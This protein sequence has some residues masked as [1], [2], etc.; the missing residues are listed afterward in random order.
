M[1]KITAIH[2]LWLI[3]FAVS[4]LLVGY[5]AIL[6]W[7]AQDG[8]LAMA[9]SFGDAFGVMNCLVSACAL[10]AIAVAIVYQKQELDETRL[11]ITKS[12]DA[13]AESVSILREEQ[14]ERLHSKQRAGTL[15]VEFLSCIT[16]RSNTD[17]TKI[18]YHIT[19]KNIG[20]TVFC[21]C[22]GMYIEGKELGYSGCGHGPMVVRNGDTF[23]TLVTGPADIDSAA[24]LMQF[25]LTYHDSTGTKREQRYLLQNRHGTVTVNCLN[26]GF[27][28]NMPPI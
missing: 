21:I 11:Q 17:T 28:N 3:G 9:S 23:E 20:E 4:A 15:F 1:S 25:R 12:A 14:T 22:P 26:H 2:V 6:Y 18:K 7:Y 24:E 10:V 5:G 16:G 8:S 19:M 27:P 13:H